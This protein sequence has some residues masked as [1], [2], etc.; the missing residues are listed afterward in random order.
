M[1]VPKDRALPAVSDVTLLSGSVSRVSGAECV[2]AFCGIA[3]DECALGKS[4]STQLMSAPFQ[5]IGPRLAI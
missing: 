2:S 1:P 4:G 3:R 5:R